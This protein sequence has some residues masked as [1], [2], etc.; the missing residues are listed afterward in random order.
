MIAVTESHLSDDILDAEVTRE[1]PGYDILR[2]DRLDRSHG[3]VAAYIR[4]DLS[5]DII[6]KFSNGACEFL[7]VKIH[8]L[9]HLCAI[10]YRPPDA[11]FR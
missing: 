4:S 11:T 3:G 2:C 7:L 6:E 10:I 1:I 5:G 8:K 9:K